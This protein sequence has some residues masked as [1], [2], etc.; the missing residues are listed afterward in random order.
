MKIERTRA[1]SSSVRLERALENS[2]GGNLAPLIKCEI[3]YLQH[4]Q[5]SLIGLPISTFAHF[6]K[7]TFKFQFQ[8]CMNCQIFKWELEADHAVVAAGPDS[9]L[10]FFH[11]K[12]KLIEC[13]TTKGKV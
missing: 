4:R 5:S 9:G 11:T 6:S 12:Q 1:I 3:F 2:S 10:A 8:V 13:Y 7:D